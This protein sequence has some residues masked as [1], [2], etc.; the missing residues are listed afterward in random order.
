MAM[1][2]DTIIPPDPLPPVRPDPG[3]MPM[4]PVPAPTPPPP[5]P[6][7]DPMPEPDPIATGSVRADVLRRSD[8]PVLV[9]K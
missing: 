1:K 4:P 3:P 5:P 7:P 9:V 8:I 2:L 6:R